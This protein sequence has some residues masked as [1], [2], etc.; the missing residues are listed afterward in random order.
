MESKV[1]TKEDLIKRILEER[2]RLLFFGVTSIGLFG[3][4]GRG[5]Q[6]SSSDVDIL[7][8]FTP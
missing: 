5:E 7:V 4:F 1:S 6:T 2:E 3:S 8:E